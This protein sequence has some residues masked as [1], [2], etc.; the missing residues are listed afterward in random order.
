MALHE[1]SESLP[2]ILL[3]FPKLAPGFDPKMADMVLNMGYGVHEV[4]G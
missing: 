2:A 4:Y 1:I 3:D